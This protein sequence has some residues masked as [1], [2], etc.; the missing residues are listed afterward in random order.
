MRI[1]V[2]ALG[3]VVVFVASSLAVLFFYSTVVPRKALQ[4]LHVSESADG[5]PTVTVDGRLLGGMTA[6]HGAKQYQRG[7]DI[8]LV[9]RAGITRAGM[10]DV[11][12][13][14]EIEIPGDV[15]QISFG[16]AEDVIWRRK[17]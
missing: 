2:Y 1:V 13:H 9:V 5:H 8:V 4:E 12:F 14:Y 7:S 16:N 10:R 6:I 15:D 11:R 17:R 3:A